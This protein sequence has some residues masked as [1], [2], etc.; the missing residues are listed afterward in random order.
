LGL[1]WV[2][3]PLFWHC[4]PL[5]WG[6]AFGSVRQRERRKRR[7]KRRRHVEEDETVNAVEAQINVYYLEVSRI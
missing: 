4:Q 3:E 6:A 7:R 1:G 2:I 5:K